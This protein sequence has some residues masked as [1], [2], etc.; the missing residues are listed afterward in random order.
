MVRLSLWC[1]AEVRLCRNDTEFRIGW[2]CAQ[3]LN[4]CAKSKP[5]T[6]GSVQ[7]CSS[8][9]TFTCHSEALT[10]SSTCPQ[11]KTQRWAQAVFGGREPS[12]PDAFTQTL[13]IL[14]F[15]RLAGVGCGFQRGEGRAPP[16]VL[17]P[18]RPGDRVGWGGSHRVGI[19]R[20]EAGGGGRGQLITLNQQLDEVDLS[21]LFGTRVSM[22]KTC[23]LLPRRQCFSVALRERH[24]ARQA[25]DTLAEECPW[26]LFGLMPMMMLHRPRGPGAVRRNELAQRADGFARGKWTDV[27]QDATQTIVKPRLETSS[28]EMEE[29]VQRGRAALN[30][31][32]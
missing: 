25:E 26:K 19:A 17:G 30:R 27:L 4:F 29:A 20:G 9:C 18:L 5:T 11:L 31:V 16:Q 10:A 6:A 21:E 8:S 3:S 1:F 24:R 28:N 22:L 2:E 14:F 7:V 15:A 13:T 12:A 23:P 32:Q